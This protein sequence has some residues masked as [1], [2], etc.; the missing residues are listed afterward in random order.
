MAQMTND[1]IEAAYQQQQQTQAQIESAYQQ[2]GQQPQSPSTQQMAQQASQMPQGQAPGQIPVSPGLGYGMN[3]M[4]AISANSLLGPDANKAAIAANIDL[5]K[6]V[7]GNP[8]KAAGSALDAQATNVTEAQKSVARDSA[9]A[10]MMAGVG[11]QMMD[12]YDQAD[13]NGLA[14]DKYRAWFGQKIADGSFPKEMSGLLP[15]A[16]PVGAFNTVGN[17]WKTRMSPIMQEQFGK[18][19]SSR[20]MDSMLSMMDKE[21]PGLAQPRNVVQSQ[22]KAT[23]K[24]LVRFTFASGDYISRLGSNMNIDGNTPQ[25]TVDNVAKK[26]WNMSSVS[27]NPQIEKKADD[28][29]AYITK[30]NDYQFAKN[31]DSGAIAIKENGGKKWRMLGQ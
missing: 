15:D 4:P 25:A 14:G 9:D 8:I 22:L 13:K 11:R 5:Q 31:P 12:Y 16:S 3:T 26:L 28:I 18:E 10:N 2:Q 6:Q 29:A 20:I 7:L 23:Y 24:N 21:V 1:Q 17:E 19:G 27:L 30:D